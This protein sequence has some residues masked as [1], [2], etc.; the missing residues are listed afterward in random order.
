[1]TDSVDRFITFLQS[2]VAK[3]DRGALAK[4]RRGLGKT[5]GEA[6]EMLPLVVPKLPENRTWEHDAYFLVA[7]LFALHPPG[8]SQRESPPTETV[9]SSTDDAKDGG[10]ETK[11]EP[12]KDWGRSLGWTFHGLLQ[13]DS[14]NSDSLDKRFMALLD[15]R[16][17]DLGGHLRYAVSL[18][19]S[20]EVRIDYARLLR[21]ILAWEHSGHR[22]KRQWA[23][24]F[25]G[26]HMPK[27]TENDPEN[28][29]TET[30]GTD[31]PNS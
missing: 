1:M 21:D 6:V 5:P 23:L 26:Q 30:A 20:K 25:W 4:L 14:N 29:T 7:S 17:D 2:L 16:A 28:D 24:D 27:N 10:G 18:A 8:P 9:E 15:S 31:H 12:S 22:V 19:K 11:A 13:E 3:E